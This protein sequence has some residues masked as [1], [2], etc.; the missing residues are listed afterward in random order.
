MLACTSCAQSG[1]L[2]VLM[3]ATKLHKYTIAASFLVSMG[4]CER[5]YCSRQGY[6]CSDACKPAAVTVQ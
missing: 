4:C 5:K 6:G 3:P 1:L 2:M